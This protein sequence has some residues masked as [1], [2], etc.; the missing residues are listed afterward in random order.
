[1]AE[2]LPSRVPSGDARARPN[3]GVGTTAPRWV[4]VFA[5]VTLLL[6]AVFVVLHLTGR[7]LG[8]HMPSGAHR[9]HISGNGAP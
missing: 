1:M 5:V 3:G 9:M 7:Q 8:G 6:L 2:R 4:K